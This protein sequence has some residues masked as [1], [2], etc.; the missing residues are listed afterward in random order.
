MSIMEHS[1]YFQLKTACRLQNKNI[2]QEYQNPTARKVEMRGLFDI[3]TKIQFSAF[4]NR[5]LFSKNNIL[6]VCYNFKY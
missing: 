6:L 1:T 3:I 5:K 2:R 4:K